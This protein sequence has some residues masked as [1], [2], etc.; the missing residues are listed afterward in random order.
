MNLGKVGVNFKGGKG[1]KGKNCWDS[2]ENKLL[3]SLASPNNILN[4]LPKRSR[5]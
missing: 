4:A 5:P 1:S 3:C 2:P